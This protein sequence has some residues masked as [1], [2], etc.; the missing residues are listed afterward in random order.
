MSMPIAPAYP[1]AL[2]RA[3][4]KVDVLVAHQPFPLNDAGIALGLPQH[5]A[6]VVHWHSEIIG[7]RAIAAAL[8]PLI[9]HTLRRAD[10]IIVS[11]GS[12]ISTSKFLRPHAEKCRIVPFGTDIDYWDSLDE[13]QSA[14]VER[15]RQQHPRLVVAIGRL[16][17]Y[18]GFL[19]L[20]RALPDVDAT[21]MI[22]GEGPMKSALER[23]ARRLRSRRPPL[24]QRLGATP[25]A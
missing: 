20:V 14:E 23:L 7:R 15:L 9:R 25:S 16:V 12:M 6:L 18:K 19:P 24:P 8:A 22:L 2:R 17:P 4:A 13:R 5:V 1:L 11:D 21:M 3:A 10:A